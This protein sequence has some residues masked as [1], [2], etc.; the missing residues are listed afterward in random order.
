MSDDTIEYA[1]SD[2]QY[3]LEQVF[4]IDR[5][6]DPPIEDTRCLDNYH[7]SDRA[8]DREGLTDYLSRNVGVWR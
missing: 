6:R 3:L 8:I 1:K 2:W 7:R 5:E 4:A